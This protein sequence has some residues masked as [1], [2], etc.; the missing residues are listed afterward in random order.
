MDR[1]PKAPVAGLAAATLGHA[2]K[3][4]NP[5]GYSARWLRLHAADGA[6]SSEQAAFSLKEQTG[7]PVQ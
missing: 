2:R 7:E 4:Q 5:L 3:P 1:I 6:V